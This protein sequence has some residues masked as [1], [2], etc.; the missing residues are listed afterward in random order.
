MSPVS[1]SGCPALLMSPSGGNQV[2]GLPPAISFSKC[3]YLWSV[4]VAFD[5][6][7]RIFEY[8]NERMQKESP[9]ESR[10]DD[11]RYSSKP[12]LAITKMMKNRFF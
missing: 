1:M 2:D 9:R 11:F 6:F 10:K 12:N 4:P 5:N 8:F 7:P 3:S